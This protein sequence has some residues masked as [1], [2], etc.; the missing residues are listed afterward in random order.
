MTILTILEEPAE[1]LYKISKPISAVTF[2]VEKLAKDMVE[3]M[4]A[5]NGIGLAAPQVGYSI[6]MI[7]IDIDAKKEKSLVLINPEIFSCPDTK[8]IEYN[9]GCLS[10]PGFESCKQRMNKIRVKATLLDSKEVTFVASGINAICIQ[11][12]VDHLNGVLIKDP[13]SFD[14]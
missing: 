1:I 6:R 13:K 5:T 4:Y 2:E 11:H 3:T 10:V 14:V 12:E 7:A 8:M 9:E